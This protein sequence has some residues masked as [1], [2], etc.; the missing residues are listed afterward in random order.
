MVRFTGIAV[1]SYNVL[2]TSTFSGV[3]VTSQVV[4]STQQ[5]TFTL[6]TAFWILFIVIP[7]AIFATITAE[8]DNL[9]KL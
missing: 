9:V 2:L 7:E 1:L 4:Y 3:F 5:V 8:R 6:S